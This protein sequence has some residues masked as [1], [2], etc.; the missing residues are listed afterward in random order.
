LHGCSGGASTIQDDLATVDPMQRKFRS[1]KCRQVTAK[2]FMVR[3]KGEILHVTALLWNVSTQ[4]IYLSSVS[5]WR[6][7]GCLRLAVLPGSGPC[8]SDTH[9]SWRRS[10]FYPEMRV[11]RY[12][13]HLLSAASA[14]CFCVQRVCV[15][16]SAKAALLPSLQ[17]KSAGGR[18][19]VN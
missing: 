18:R 7:R 17:G 10:C 12:Q 2:A 4:P 14:C 13:D 11:P 1:A 8:S 16:S 5:I 6:K 9:V 19:T 3:R 15:C